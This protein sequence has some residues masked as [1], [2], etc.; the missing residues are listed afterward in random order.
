MGVNGNIT[1]TSF[2]AFSNVIKKEDI[3]SL[4]VALTNLD[5][6]KGNVQNCNC[7]PSNCC[8]SSTCETCQ[9]TCQSCQGCETCQ[10]CQG[11]QS[12]CSSAC[13]SQCSS[14]CQSCQSCKQCQY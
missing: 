2:T 8:Q 10:G 6:L 1:P 12:M 13:E 5:N 4:R 11:C 3:Q 7:S 9:G 14:Y